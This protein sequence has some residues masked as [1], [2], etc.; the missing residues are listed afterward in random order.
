MLIPFFSFLFALIVLWIIGGALDA[1][2][3]NPIIT[4]ASTDKRV[5]AAL[6]ERDR[7]AEIN[8]QIKS[9]D[10]TIQ[11]APL[12]KLDINKS[13]LEQTNIL[14]SGVIKP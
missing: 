6:D 8:E 4:T 5:K 3:D 11:R 9:L 1:P 14:P 10:L 7:Q 13:M 2:T 12:E